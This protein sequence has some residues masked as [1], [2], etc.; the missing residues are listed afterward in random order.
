MR[1]E[2]EGLSMARKITA[3]LGSKIDENGDIIIQMKGEAVEKAY[4]ILFTR[5]CATN[6]ILALVA[7][8][9]KSQEKFGDTKKVQPAVLTGAQIFSDPQ[10][11]SHISLILGHLPIP[12]AIDE[13]SAR[14]LQSV[15]KKVIAS[16]KLRPVR[17]ST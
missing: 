12:L 14:G 17:K 1:K 2:R 10:G 5:G 13:K 7:Q 15:L 8:I 9:H 4:A 16:G 3:I 6:L 11:Y